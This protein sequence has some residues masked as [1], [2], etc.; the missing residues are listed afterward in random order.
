M[1][2]VATQSCFTT[3][4]LALIPLL[5]PFASGVQLF[6]AFGSGIQ[7]FQTFG[8]GNQL[9]QS[10]GSAIS[11][12]SFCHGSENGLD[13]QERALSVLRQSTQGGFQ[14]PIRISKTLGPISLPATNTLR[15]TERSMK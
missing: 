4:W 5:L 6:Q 2:P 1:R 13:V 14:W 12:S 11:F 9:F 3:P 10:F 8:L 7:R 15:P